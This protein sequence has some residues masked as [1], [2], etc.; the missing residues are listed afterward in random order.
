MTSNPF[1][2]RLQELQQTQV[3]PTNISETTTQ[4]SENIN[5]F[6]KRL[7]EKEQVG[8]SLWNGFY[9]MLF[10]PKETAFEH[11]IGSAMRGIGTSIVGF[12]GD[13]TQMAKGAGEWLEKKFPTPSIFRRE[14]S[15]VQK[16][17]KELLDKVPTT[18]Q[19]MDKYDEMTQGKYVP[20]TRSEELLQQIG[21]DV[22]LLMM[23]ATTIGKAS[24]A[25]AGGVLGNL[26]SEGMKD[27]EYGEGA[28]AG[29]K[30]GTIMAVSLF[31]P[32]GAKKFT[33]HLYDTAYANL[34]QD[35]EISG[36]GLSKGLNNLQ[37]NLKKGLVN[38]ESKKPV[39][40]AINDVERNIKD[41]KVNIRNLTE[42]KRNL[43]EQRSAK[44]YDPEFKGTRKARADLKKNYSRLASVIDDAI[45]EYGQT[46]ESFY[47]PY[48]DANQ[49]WGGN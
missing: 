12:P 42:A 23:P 1:A 20:K 34:P 10:S 49:A 8:D 48:K 28:Q 25:I 45:E 7:E 46:N 4:K 39:L 36:V 26:A 33:N 41:G 14:S 2:V 37:T 31:N 21:G 44:V 15:I 18:S 16:A 40:N 24:K 11:G 6:K 22:A 19:L 17:G 38:V 29:A 27:L 3:A 9:D 30:I 43:N 35:A 32:T 13:I 47:R 5:P